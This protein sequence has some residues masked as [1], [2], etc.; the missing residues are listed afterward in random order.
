MKIAFG[1][2]EGLEYLHDK[3]N[4]PVIFGDL[5]PT[6][7]LLDEDYTSKLSD[8]GLVKF[9]PS[10]DSVPS[11]L[12]GTYG[13]S[14]PEYA[15]GGE[16]T[17]KSDVYSFGVILLE[18]ITG[19]KAIDTTKPNDEQNLVAWVSNMVVVVVIVVVVVFIV[20]EMNAGKHFHRQNV[21]T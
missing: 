6:N 18:L 8:F 12:M 19:R 5:K 4:P 1:T 20:F 13:Y 17:M 11:R 7:I 3:A 2:A 21:I 9:G 14:A 10:G 16:L 15:R